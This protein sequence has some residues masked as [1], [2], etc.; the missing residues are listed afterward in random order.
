[1]HCKHSFRSVTFVGAA[2]LIGAVGTPSEAQTF[3][4]RPITFIFPYAAGSASDTAYR[5]INQEVGK[6]LGQNVVQENRPGAGGRVGIDQV[7]RSAKDGHTLGMLVN[8]VAVVH[9]LVDSA[10]RLEPG[11]EYT[12]IS[13]AY[14]TYYVLVVHP[15]TPF[16]DLKGLVAYAKANPGKLNAGTPGAGTGGHLA[17]ALLTSKAGIK[18]TEI[19]YK[20]T[21][22]ALTGMLS[23][24]V[25]IMFVDPAGKPHVDAGKFVAIGTSA[26]KRWSIFPNL[27][28]IEQA[29][30]P[31]YNSST[32]TGVVGPS[33]LSNDVV[34]KLNKAYND[35]LSSPEVRAKIE[36]MG[37]VIRGNASPGDFTALVRSDLETFRPIVREANIKLD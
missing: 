5:T 1:M 9:P 7:V 20:G 4:N 29:G 31:G 8:G 18:V 24:D 23:G 13:L 36:G 34:G 12:P 27:P 3:P 21:A 15:S 37:F 16:R 6:R 17:L 35:A 14:D 2:L 28:T 19:H 11:K 22:P 25:N 32:W 10:Y 26:A 30:V 33:G